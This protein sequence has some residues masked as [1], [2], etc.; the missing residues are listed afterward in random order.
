MSILSVELTEENK[1]EVRVVSFD[2]KGKIDSISSKVPEQENLLYAYF[3]MDDMIP[4]MQ[5]TNKMSDY[6]VSK[7]KDVFTYEIIKTKVS[8]KKRSK[9]SQLF[10][11]PDV[12]NVDI[13][14]TYDGK[15]FKFIPSE[16]IVKGSGV[17]N[18]QQVTVG[19]KYAHV[20]FITHDNKPEHLI[21]TMQIPFADLLSGPVSIKFDYNKY[22]ISLY[23][24]KFLE[25]YSFRRL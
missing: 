13:D 25:T 8:I 7:T 19:G 18:S 5:G 4:F 24:Q 1:R 3:T 20:F 11:I 16:E 12:K 17:N 6:L 22:S 15:E 9:E 21:Q 2:E 23:T 10:Q 14:I